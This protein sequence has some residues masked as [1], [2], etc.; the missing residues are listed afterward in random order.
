[1]RVDD[2]DTAGVTIA[3]ATHA[4]SIAEDS[5]GTYTVRLASEPTGD[6][7]VTINDPAGTDITASPDTLTFSK[8]G[9]N[10]WSTPKTVTVSVASDTDFADDIAAITHT[11]SGG[12]Y[13]HVNA[14][15]VVITATEAGEPG[16]TFSPSSVDVD[17]DS[18]WRRTTWSLRLGL[19]AR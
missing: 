4:L 13:D 11:L 1:M 9:A 15:A 10:I 8:T 2:D 17:E 3:P 14:P 7:T 19:P 12:G 5:E 6:V 16:F 18:E